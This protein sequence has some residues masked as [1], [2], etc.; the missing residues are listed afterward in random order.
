MLMDLCASITPVHVFTVNV[1]GFALMFAMNQLV[2][3]VEVFMSCSSV[4]EILVLSWHTAFGVGT[5]LNLIVFEI[6][7]DHF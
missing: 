3:N 4:I 2:N 1:I 5:Y 7:V 6:K